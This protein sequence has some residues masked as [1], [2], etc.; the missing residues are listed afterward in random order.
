MRSRGSL[1]YL[2][3]HQK[4]QVQVTGPSGNWI[5]LFNGNDPNDWIVKIAGLDLNDSYR[6]TFRVEDALLIVLYPDYDQFGED[7]SA[8]SSKRKEAVS[9]LV[10]SG[11]VPLCRRQSLGAPSWACKES[12]IRLH[13]RSPEFMRK[14]QEFPANAKVDLVSR[15]FFGKRP[16]GDI[17]ETARA[18]ISI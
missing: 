16:T 11:R 1:R 4:P 12:G 6:N 2:R 5:S 15:R 14:Y 17:C 3:A 10:D 8:V 9:P 7:A 13:G 18:S